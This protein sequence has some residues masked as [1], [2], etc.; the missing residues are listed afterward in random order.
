VEALVM[1][2]SNGRAYSVPVAQLPSARGDG[3]PVSAFIE[4][5]TG[6]QIVGYAAGEAAT[7]LVLATSLGYG[8]TCSQG[9]LVSRQKAGKQFLTL[10]EP[11][12]PL[13]PLVVQP[14][15]D[16]LVACLSSLGRL[17]VFEAAELRQLAGGGRGVILMDLQL[18]ETLLAAQPCGTAGLRVSGTGR[19]GKPAEIE[20][21]GK[22]LEAYRGKRA[23]KGKTLEIKF[24]AE[25]L[26]RL[27]APA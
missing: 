21:K 8:F 22:A 17:L 16:S 15:T 1:L 23:R 27:A 7:P 3:L 25:R 26:A 19:G 11:A 5:P 4:L 2:G 10:D 18:G 6:V 9:D 24:K 20:L 12:V 13:A 14:S